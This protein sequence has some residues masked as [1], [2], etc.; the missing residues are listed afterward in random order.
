MADSNA[1][2]KDFNF[3]D[4][5]SLKEHVESLLRGME[6]R[7]EQAR[8]SMEKRLDGMNEFRDTLKDQAARFVVRDDLIP[9]RKDIDEMKSFQDKLSGKASQQDVNRANFFAIAGFA[10]GIIGILLRFLGV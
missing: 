4:G 3:Q 1:P 7:T 5:V 6:L 8:V 9:I 10:L 2:H